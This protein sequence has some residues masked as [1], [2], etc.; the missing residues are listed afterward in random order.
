MFEVD[1]RY[2]LK[3]G[4]V[5]SLD[6]SFGEVSS[7]HFDMGKKWDNFTF[8]TCIRPHTLSLFPLVGR[9]G[10]K[11]FEHTAM[12]VE[13]HLASLALPENTA[14]LSCV[15][16]KPE[17][18]GQHRLRRLL[19][20]VLDILEE[21]SCSVCLYTNEL[22]NV[23]IYERLGFRTVDT[24]RHARIPCSSYFMLKNPLTL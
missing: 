10:L 3:K 23:A 21:N 17:Y 12:E 6:K 15:G 19:S 4:A 1:I 18:R 9:E 5:F 2:A 7:W 8:L 11:S 14:Y 13:G 16:V 20:P 24:I 22:K